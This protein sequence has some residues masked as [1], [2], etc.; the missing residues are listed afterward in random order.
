MVLSAGPEV[1]GLTHDVRVNFAKATIV[2]MSSIDFTIARGLGHE[3][4]SIT[5]VASH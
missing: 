1:G 3:Q 5:I 4:K 2:D